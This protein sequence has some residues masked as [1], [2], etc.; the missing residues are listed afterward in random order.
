MLLSDVPELAAHHGPNIPAIIFQGEIITYL[1][2]RDRCRRLANALIAVTR[3][4]DRVAI[5]A[6]N[7]PEYVDCYY[8]VPGAA[9][10]LTLLN[11]RLAPREL[12]YIIGDAEPRPQ[13]RVLGD[14]PDPVQPLRRGAASSLD[15]SRAG[16]KQARRH[17]H[18][19]GL[20]GAVR[21]DQRHHAPGWHV[22]VAVTQAP[23]LAPVTVPEACAPQ[24]RAHAAPPAVRRSPGLTADSS[25]ATSTSIRI[26]SEP[27]PS[28][29]ARS[30]QRASE[31]SSFGATGTD[32]RD[33]AAATNVPMP[34]RRTT[35]P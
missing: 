19:G 6:E 30:T 24:R 31:P 3:P 9:L 22:Q 2:M 23:D 34:C 11:Y 20:A 33:G 12:A 10:A 4:G 7:C 13:R 17:A 28:R 16:R 27:S 21:A 35:S 14:E 25:R 32:V 18:Q 1:Q 15:T 26:C 8:G 5:L 29:L